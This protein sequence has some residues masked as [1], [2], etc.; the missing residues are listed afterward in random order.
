MSKKNVHVTHR[1]DEKKWA[2]KK[3]GNEKASALFDTKKEAEEFG[4]EQ[5]KKE[6]SELVIHNKDG[7]ISD[8][9][10]FGND[11]S[12]VKDKIH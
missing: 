7:K 5:A 8:K 4:R 12:T 3:E 11:S 10:S 2:V 9:D 6:K 1:K